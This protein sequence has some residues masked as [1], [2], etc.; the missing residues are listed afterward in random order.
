M[1]RLAHFPRDKARAI[2]VEHGERDDPRFIIPL[3]LGDM[4][5]LQFRRVRPGG[6]LERPT[7]RIAWIVIIDDRIRGAAGSG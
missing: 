6:D 2:F 4:Q 3:M 5:G 1:T 7:L